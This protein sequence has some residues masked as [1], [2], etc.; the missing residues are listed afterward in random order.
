MNILKKTVLA[1]AIVF[2]VLTFLSLKPK[3]QENEVVFWT[4][5]L[6]TFDNYMNPLIQEFE[7]ENPGIKIKWIDVP[8]SEGEKRT[9]DRKSVV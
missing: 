3:T 6:G 2:F 7:R 5:Q 4:L 1:L 8:Y 9:L